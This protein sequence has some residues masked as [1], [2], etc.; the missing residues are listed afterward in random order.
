MSPKTNKV[1]L[2]IL[3]S[4]LTLQFVA[5]SLGKFTGAWTPR[6]EAWGYPGVLVYVVGLLEVAAVIGLFI[7]KFRKWAVI[8]LVATMIGAAVTHI[9]NDEYS[10][11]IHNGVLILLL[12]TLNHL[13]KKRIQFSKI[14]N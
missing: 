1:L 4:I 6:F 10:R 3:I 11:L 12:L 14:N 2:W 8:L 7:A 13:D 9:L 5:A